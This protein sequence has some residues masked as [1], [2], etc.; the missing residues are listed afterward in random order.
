VNAD[1]LVSVL[2]LST[3]AQV[4]GNCGDIVKE[5]TDGIVQVATRYFA[6]RS[7]LLHFFFTNYPVNESTPSMAICALIEMMNHVL[8]EERS[9]AERLFGPLLPS[10]SIQ[11]K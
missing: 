9:I 7:S 6:S 4:L 1:F 3:A 11:Y 5:C 2:K 10:F 8:R